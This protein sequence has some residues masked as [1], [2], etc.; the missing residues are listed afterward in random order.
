MTAGRLGIEARRSA[1]RYST[2]YD[3][4]AGLR[5][6][7]QLHGRAERLHGSE[8][9][10]PRGDDRLDSGGGQ[11]PER[12][13]VLHVHLPQHGPV[14]H[15]VERIGVLRQLVVRPVDRARVSHRRRNAGGRAREPAGVR[16]AEVVPE[17]VR[18]HGHLE[19]AVDPD[20]RPADLGQARPSAGRNVREDEHPVLEGRVVHARRVLGLRGPGVEIVGSCTCR[21]GLRCRTGPNTVPENPIWPYVC[22]W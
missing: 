7:E 6:T 8:L 5:Q 21:S 13:L 4:T 19:V 18:D 1:S 9:I 22:S 16:D 14:A 2:K 15:R 11:Q 20:V 3:A 12:Q 17:L 10:R